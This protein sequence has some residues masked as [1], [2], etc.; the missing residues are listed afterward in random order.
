MTETMEA[1]P[2]APGAE[3]H[4]VALEALGSGFGTAYPVC[5]AAAAVVAA[6]TAF[7]MIGLR[8][9][10]TAGDEGSDAVP[11]ASDGAAPDPVTAR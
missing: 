3:A 10:G 2:G 1:P 9:P 7:G 5:G 8:G 6:P 11:S 4:G